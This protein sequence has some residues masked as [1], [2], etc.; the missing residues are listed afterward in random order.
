MER[1][2]Q[3]RE[4][5]SP[6]ALRDALE[7]GGYLADDA[8][9]TVMFL[10]LRLERPLL[11]EGPAGAG[12]TELALA[13]ARISGAPLVRLQ[14]YEGIDVTQAVYEW[15]YR[16]QLLHLRA[17]EATAALE[18]AE[19]PPSGVAGLE[20]EL[21]DERFLIRRPVLAA[22]SAAAGAPPPVLLIDE[23]DRGDEELEA[24]LLEALSTY[25]VTVPEL[26]TIRAGVVPVVVLTS[27]RTRAL[28]DALPRRCLYHWL[29]HPSREREVRII[30]RRC[31]D[32]SPTLVEEVAAA[33]EQLRA[34]DL[35]K[36][37]GVA[38]S[39]DW[40]NALIALGARSLDGDAAG[41]T[42]G[43]VLKNDDDVRRAADGG[44]R[45]VKGASTSGG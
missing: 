4:I 27:N 24:Y 45:L 6:E 16:R 34:L 2:V 44:L 35:E 38:E 32:L 28:H 5:G 8:L 14:C 41:R 29:A 26:G 7:L 10:A 13:L 1:S 31:P 19:G 21:F 37:P 18:H 36:P 22:L 30:Q 3:L 33:C 23:V 9:A 12:K 40:A 20:A 43:V 15:D 25:S 42:L 17:V 39:V 11:L